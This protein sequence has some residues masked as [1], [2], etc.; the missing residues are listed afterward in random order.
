MALWCMSIIIRR[1]SNEVNNKIARMAHLKACKVPLVKDS[2]NKRRQF[3]VLK[4]TLWLNDNLSTCKMIL[5]VL[6]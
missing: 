4:G 3:K 2:W 6:L 5:Q 1:L